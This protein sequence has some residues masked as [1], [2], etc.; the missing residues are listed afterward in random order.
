MKREEIVKV[1]EA[2]PEAVIQLVTGLIQ[3]FISQTYCRTV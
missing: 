1:Y 3:E 2:D